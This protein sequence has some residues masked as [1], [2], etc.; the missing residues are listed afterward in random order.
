MKFYDRTK[1][2]S[3]NGGVIRDCVCSLPLTHV[4]PGVSR[5]ASVSLVP[6]MS[7]ELIIIRPWESCENE[8]TKQL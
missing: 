5:P 6:H 3:G 2:R 7:L 1:H 8:I 4:G